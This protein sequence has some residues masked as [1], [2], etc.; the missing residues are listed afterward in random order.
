MSKVLQAILSGAVL[1]TWFLPSMG[2]GASAPSSNE[3]VVGGP[4]AALA[5]ALMFHAGFDDGWDAA[6][7]LGERR[8]YSAASYEKQEEATPGLVSSD[9]EIV[10]NGHFQRALKFNKKNTQAIFYRAENNVAYSPSGWSG[11][12]SF[13]LSLDPAQDLEPGFCDPIQITDSAYNDACI[14]ADFTRDNPRQ[15]RMGVFGDLAVWNPENV[16]PDKNPNFTSRLV[17]VDQPPFARGQWTQVVITHEGL[18]GGKGSA[19]LYLNGRLRGEATGI[20]EPFTW[21][22]S[23][24]A[25][26]LGVNYVGLY[27]EIAIFNRRLTDEEIQ[28]LYTL[29]EGI[30]SLHR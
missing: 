28:T 18:G 6:F 24:A 2:C 5:D 10:D 14:W 11:T 19:R 12:I 30:V 20:S 15:F 7:A 3:S 23:K 17:A 26:R 16:P 8:L 22:V 21:D 9:V 4:A 29:K 25:I 27:D 1:L 13:W